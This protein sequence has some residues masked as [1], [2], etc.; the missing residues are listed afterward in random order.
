MYTKK[1][2]VRE[3][4]YKDKL[5]YEIENDQIRHAEWISNQKQRLIEKE[6]Y[7]KKRIEERKKALEDRPN[8]YQKEI[9]TCEHLI[10]FCN[11][12]KVQYGTADTTS[13]D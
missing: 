9:D 8:P 3:Q 4:Y 12:L 10:A 6:E 5:E 2:E 7:K 1:D 11:K 13:E